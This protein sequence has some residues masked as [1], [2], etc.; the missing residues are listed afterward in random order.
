MAIAMHVKFTQRREMR[1][2]WKYEQGM[3]FESSFRNCTSCLH[4]LSSQSD[5]LWPNWFL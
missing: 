1:K 3:I 5:A 2:I 4:H